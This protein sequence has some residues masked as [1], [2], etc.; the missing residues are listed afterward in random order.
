[1]Q[2][3]LWI[4]S[5]KEMRKMLIA[6][7]AVAVSVFATS[8]RAE[9]FDLTLAST[10]SAA[11][12]AQ[13]SPTDSSG[14]WESAVGDGFRSSA[15]LLNFETGLAFGVPAFGGRQV[16]D[17]ALLSSSYGHMLD[18][19]MGEGHWYRGNLEFRAELWGGGQYSPDRALLVGLTPHF[20]Y[21]FA[22]GTR[23]IPFLDLGAGVTASGIGPPDQSGVFEFNLQ[24][25]VGSYWFIRDNIALTAD[26]GYLHMSCAG[27][28]SP[29]LGVNAIKGMLGITFFF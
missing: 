23:W 10:N 24:G 1:L 2:E 25:N 19:V 11:G 18:D 22:T 14:I 20:R 12:S 21:D 15:Q 6:A 26:I 4:A 8:A 27:I 9:N 16:H 13:V 3:L 5:G 29:N 28:H 7:V 17:L